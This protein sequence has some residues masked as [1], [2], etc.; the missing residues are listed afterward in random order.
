VEAVLRPFC[1]LLGLF[2]P[3]NWAEAGDAVEIT[4][5]IARKV[6]TAS[7]DVEVGMDVDSGER[8]MAVCHRAV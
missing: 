3:N 8:N 5:P 1:P 4:T 2:C 6:I 7:G